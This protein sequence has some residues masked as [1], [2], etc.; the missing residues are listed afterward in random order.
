M[1]TMTQTDYLVLFSCFLRV[2]SCLIMSFLMSVFVKVGKVLLFV[3]SS[4]VISTKYTGVDIL[5]Y[6][7]FF[8]I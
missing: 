7:F 6:H 4:T 5:L 8:F 1:L 3:Y 2:D